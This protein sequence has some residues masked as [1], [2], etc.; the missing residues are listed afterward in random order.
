MH[1]LFV[2]CLLPAVANAAALP[3]LY[4]VIDLSS[5]VLNLVKTK[6]PFLTTV[7]NKQEQ[8][9]ANLR[10]TPISESQIASLEPQ[11]RQLVVKLQ[12]VVSHPSLLDELSSS[13]DIK[14]IGE[15]AALR[16]ILPANVNN[17]NAELSRIGIYSMVSQSVTHID[18]IVSI[19]GL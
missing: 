17:F 3:A 15:L 10:N 13:D 14:V 18:S 5:T 6:F 11:L 19:L 1:V 16:K 2:V 4:Q 8:G 9:I 7:V 12:Y